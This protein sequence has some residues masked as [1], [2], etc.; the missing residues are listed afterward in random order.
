MVFITDT[1]ASSL[2][3]VWLVQPADK[4][5]GIRLN[6]SQRKDTWSNRCELSLS[7]QKPEGSLTT[8]LRMSTKYTWVSELID[9]P[10][11]LSQHLLI[12]QKKRSNVS[13]PHSIQVPILQVAYSQ[14]CI[15]NRC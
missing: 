9:E 15:L 6:S 11:P 13:L 7:V 12:F 4:S 2:I 14:M 5:G 8:L 3:V 1:L 10:R